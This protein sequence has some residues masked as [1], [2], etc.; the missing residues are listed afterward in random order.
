MALF[1]CLSQLGILALDSPFIPE[2]AQEVFLK[3]PE[4]FI[5]AETGQPL[6]DEAIE[7][8]VPVGAQFS[9]D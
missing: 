8:S 7:F 3:L 5:D 9:R 2:P 6:S 4:L 1:R